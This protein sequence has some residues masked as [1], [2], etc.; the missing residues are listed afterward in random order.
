MKYLLGFIALLVI[1]GG[2]YYGINHNNNS[3]TSPSINVSNNNGVIDLSNQGLTKV[4]PNIY[5]QTDTSELILSNN[6]IKTLPSQMGGMTKLVIFKIDHNLLEGSLI[7][8][9][10]QMSQLILLDAS[11]NH[12]TGV[13]AEIG[14]LSKLQT[15]NLSYNKIT[16]LPNEMANLKPNLKELDLIG[17][18]LSQTTITKLQT[19]LPNTKIVF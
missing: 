14:Q 13:P 3:K 11:Y 18:P 19:E 16:E 5:N 4:T 10:R 9:I 17:N 15:L 8:E 12:M 7:G 6:S 2:L 1:A